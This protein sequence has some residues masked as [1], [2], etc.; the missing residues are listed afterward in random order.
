MPQ[1][2]KSKATHRTDNCCK[3]ATV[4]PDFSF[5]LAATPRRAALTPQGGVSENAVASPAHRA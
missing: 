4:V 2:H 5:C 3:C 1:R